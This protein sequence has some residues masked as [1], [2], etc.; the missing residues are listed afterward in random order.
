M[1]ED[2]SRFHLL[3]CMLPIFF[4]WKEP[5][6]S[7]SASVVFRPTSGSSTMKLIS[8]KRFNLVRQESWPTIHPNSELF[9]RTAKTKKSNA[10]SKQWTESAN[11]VNFVGDPAN[12]RRHLNFLNFFLTFFAL[13]KSWVLRNWSSALNEVKL[14]WILNKNHPLSVRKNQVWNK[15]YLMIKTS[16]ST[17]FLISNS[18]AGCGVW[19][20][21]QRCQKVLL[22]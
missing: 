15:K 16:E 10:V 5:C 11:L 19:S 6:S 4:W 7:T 3:S 13:E 22:K 17:E 20:N 8:S 21:L 14:S 2:S 1:V 9:W 12:T 18:N